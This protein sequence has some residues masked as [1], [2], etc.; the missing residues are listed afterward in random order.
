MPLTA[1]QKEAVRKA[2]EAEMDQKMRTKVNKAFPSW[3]M[4]GKA[5]D[6]VKGRKS[7]L[8]EAE[9]NALGMKKGG[10]VM[11]T[12]KMYGGGMTKRPSMPGRPAM[13]PQA[14]ARPTRPAMPP[15]AGNATASRPSPTATVPPPTTM[16]MP[17]GGRP[18]I[19][20]GMKKGGKVRGAGKAKQ[21]VSRC[22]MY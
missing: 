12:K 4:A 22:K 11:K 3:G 20:T 19:T 10:K 21:G 7:A 9:K 8:D 14:M 5:A 15:Q 1:K 13:P 6:A 17:S 18:R 16:P 2:K